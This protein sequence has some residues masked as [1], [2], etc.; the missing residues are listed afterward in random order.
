MALGKAKLTDGST[1]WYKDST[2]SHF[3]DLEKSI[4]LNIRRHLELQEGPDVG[5]IQLGSKCPMSAAA[6]CIQTRE[7]GS[8]SKNKTGRVQVNS[9]LIICFES[10]N[11][12][13]DTP[14]SK[15][16]ISQAQQS[17]L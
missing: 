15:S 5:T 7:V 4:S 1:I 12:L 10:S 9:L 3:P 11:L 17:G 8:R 6:S 2:W 16:T 13:P 14:K